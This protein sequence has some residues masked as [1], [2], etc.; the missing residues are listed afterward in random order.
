MLNVLKEK[1][2]DPLHGRLLASSR[3]VDDADVFGKDVVDVG[4]G[5]GWFEVDALRRGAHSVT[6]LEMSAGDLTTAKAHV[7]DAR[8]TF[9]VGSAIEVPS[10]DETADTVVSWEVIEHI[11]KGTEDRMFLEVR[12][13]LRP[14]GAFYLSTPHATFWSNLLDPA[15]WLVGHR[16]YS[17][18]RLRD[19]ARR[20]GFEV[21]AVALRAS[22]WTLLAV[23]DLYVAK[24]I[25]RRRPFFESF[26]NAKTDDE[27]ARAGFVNV[28]LKLRKK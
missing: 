16:H 19:F 23:L 8:A 20:H 3:F 4:C 10:G 15:W 21:V 27:Y 18:D 26:L 11:P 25:F 14:G 9:S 1:P 7:T 28:F 17:V 12:R 5:F 24:W 2:T 22:W 13:I 6:G